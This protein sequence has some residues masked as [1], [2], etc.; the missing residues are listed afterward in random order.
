LCRRNTQLKIGTISSTSESFAPEDSWNKKS[1]T[2]KLQNYEDETEVEESI[3]KLERCSPLVFAGEVRTLHENL[4]RASQGQGFLLVGSDSAKDFNVDN[5]RDSF[6]VILQMALV[7]T[8]GSAMPVIKMGRMGGQLAKVNS[9]DPAIFEESE[10][11]RNIGYP[12]LF[13]MLEEYNRSAQTLNILRAFSTGGYA[14]I[15]RLHAWNLD[16]VEQT[17][18]GSRYRKFATK[19]DESLRFMKACGVDT[20]SSAFTKTDF[21]TANE[22]ISL[23]YEQALTRQDSTTDRW[24]DFSAHMPWISEDTRQLDGAHLEFCRGLRNPLGIKVSDKCSPEELIRIID[25]L[26]PSNI[27]GRIT[28][29]VCMGAEKLRKNLPGLIRAVQRE[30]K[31]VLWISNP[32]HSVISMTEK[33]YNTNSFEKI[34]EEL[35]AFFNCHDEMRSHPGGV[36]LSLTGENIKECTGGLGGV[37]EESLTGG[38]QYPRLN[39]EQ[40]LELAFLI[41]ER[42]RLRTGLPPIE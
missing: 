17:D 10:G 22:C 13:N 19:V 12:K 29:I 7:L 14:D 16:F 1:W 4:A 27:P 34:R 40:A 3:T 42:M 6:R 26:N 28:I 8:F 23:P 31:S 24:Y 20:S 9:V 41:A 38:N 5:I 21:F 33:G 15:S 18:E 36:H 35:R 2:R 25:I 32:V 37:T 39:A 30:G 11:S